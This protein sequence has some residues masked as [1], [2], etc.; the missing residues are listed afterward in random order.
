MSLW[1]SGGGTNAG[2]AIGATDELGPK[3]SKPVHHVKD[4]HCTILRLLG[5]DD[6]KLTYFHEGR[7]R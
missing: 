1:L 6:N 4:P 7:Y 2:H 3:P 5:L